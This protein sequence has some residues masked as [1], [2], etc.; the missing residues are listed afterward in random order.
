MYAT[1]QRRPQTP[2]S[3]IIED[4][5]SI[6][7]DDESMHTRSAPQSYQLVNVQQP[8]GNLTTIRRHLSARDSGERQH[9]MAPTSAPRAAKGACRTVLARSSDGSWRRVQR[10]VR[11]SELFLKTR[12]QP[13]D[14]APLA[15]SASDRSSSIYDDD[16]SRGTMLST[17]TMVET[18]LAEQQTYQR[19]KGVQI[20]GH[21]ASG[22]SATGASGRSGNI[23][24][25][26]IDENEEF[27]RSRRY[28]ACSRRYSASDY[29]DA[30]GHGEEFERDEHRAIHRSR[31]GKPMPWLS[32]DLMI[33]TRCSTR[34]LQHLGWQ[35]CISGVW[36][37]GSSGT[38]QP[39]G[40]S[41]IFGRQQQFD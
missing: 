11:D 28:S 25:G 26:H 3:Q 31:S 38:A 32:Q 17:I 29:G 24:I 21:S 2:V 7:S 20:L 37:N 39:A 40:R 30:V 23:E 19:T 12:N 16:S 33:L 34:G 22:S 1:Q 15:R 36:T 10:P 9:V 6:V 8:N 14:S 27:D 35:G 18:A 5:A 4:Y 13:V 41:A